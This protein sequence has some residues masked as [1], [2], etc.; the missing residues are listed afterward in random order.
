MY[1]ATMNTL[2]FVVLAPSL[3]WTATA[4]GC[5]GSKDLANYNSSKTVAI[6]ALRIKDAAVVDDPDKQWYF[7]LRNQEIN[8]PGQ[9]VMT[10]MWLNTGKSNATGMG[11][12]FQTTDVYGVNGFEFSR[13]VLERSVDDKGDCKTMLGEEC[14]AALKDH[15]ARSGMK[16]AFEGTCS[17]GSFNTTVPHECA[18]LVGGETNWRGGMSATGKSRFIFSNYMDMCLRT[19]GITLDHAAYEEALEA[20][21]CKGFGANSS[22][23][24]GRGKSGTYDVSA[25][26]AQPYFLTFWPNRTQDTAS[27]GISSDEVHVELLCL[28][29]DD[30]K[31]GSSAPAPAKDLLDKLGAKSDGNVADN[32]SKTGSGSEGPSS[33]GGAAAMRTMAPYLGAAAMAGL[34]LV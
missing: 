5:K 3:I 19:V 30:I 16:S 28:K 21:G 33:T 9:D 31:E 1:P 26:F 4:Q 23:Y 34:L 17:G 12:C 14:V 25:R 32:S 20:V 29:T 7:S 24:R 13:E 11:T 6:P 10:Y 15:Y 2:A 27:N 8:G 22:M 18:G